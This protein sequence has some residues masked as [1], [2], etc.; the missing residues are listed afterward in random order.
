[1]QLKQGQ[2]WRCINGACG[3]LIQIMEGGGLENGSNPRCACGSIMKMPYVKPHF[4][5]SET[6]EEVKRL[7][8]QLYAVLR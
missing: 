6:P 2:V 3:A 4:R 7:L 8:E 5:R 1:M